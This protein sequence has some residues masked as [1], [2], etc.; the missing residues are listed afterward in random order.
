VARRVGFVAV[1]AV[2][3]A[4]FLAATTVR[5]GFF[6]LRVYHGALNLWIHG[7]GDLYD[8]VNPG[9]RYGFTYPP[10]AALTML[11]MAYLGWHTA[12]VINIVLTVVASAALLWWLVDPVARRH[13]WVRWFAFA[14]AACLL[15]A[16]EPTRETVT[17]G[18][19]NLLMLVLVVA[20]LRWLVARRSRWAG[21][22]V[23]LAT[24]IKLTPGIFIAYL[25]ISRRWRAAAVASG[26]AAVATVL[27]GLLAPAES[28]VFWTEALWNTDRVGVFAYVSNQS[29]RGAVSRLD[30]EHPD[31]VLWVVLVIAALAIWVW[32]ARAAARAGDELTGFALTAV[33][34]CLVSPVTWVHHLVWLAPALILL[35]DRAAS[36]PARSRRRRWLLG[37][38]TVSYAVLISRVIWLW[39]DGGGGVLGILGG[40]AYVWVSLALLVLLPIRSAGPR[41]QPQG[42]ADL[43]DL[44]RAPTAGAV[45]RERGPLPVGD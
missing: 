22:G 14:I 10:F 21:V 42:V 11:P 40:N 13:G 43:D 15:A 9:T 30:P 38:A 31:L 3:T 27:A 37:L 25:L 7:G 12:I 26:T 6:D 39:Q 28:R 24:A 44:G 33:V 29:L 1:L 34:G 32:R 20:D 45:D 5:H 19:V 4:A 23:G 8:Y 36:A 16:F 17:F 18:Q 41:R 35:I 2:L